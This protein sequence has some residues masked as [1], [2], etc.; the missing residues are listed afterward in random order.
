MKIVTTTIHK[1][2]TVT[3]KTEGFD[4]AECVAATEEFERRLM[5]KTS[6]TPTDEAR[7]EVQ[8]HTMKA[9]S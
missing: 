5:A 7:G 3:V 4:G 6:D 1:G 2:G 8:A 9:S